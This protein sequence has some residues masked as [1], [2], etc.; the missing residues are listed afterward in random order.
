MSEV[1]AAPASFRHALQQYYDRRLLFIFILG[2]SSG[3]PWVLIGSAMSGWLKDANLSRAA[4]G[5]FG[6]VTAVYA[7][8]FL[9][10]PLVDRV[11]MPWLYQKVGQR[12]SWVLT[13]QSMVALLTFAIAFTNPALSLL[14]TSLLALLIGLFAAT[15]DVAIDGYRIDII[16]NEP[17]KLPAAAAM[18]VAG[19]WTGYSLPGYFAFH[20]ADVIGWPTVYLGLAVMLALLATV[21]LLIKEPVTNRDLLQQKSAE[22]YQHSTQHPVTLWLLVTV[23]EPFAEFFRRNGL[24]LSVSLIVFIL[25]FKLGEAFLGRMSIQFYRE[26]GFSNEQIAE[27]SKLIGWGATLAFTLLGSLLNVRFGV[28]KGLMLG[29][30]TMAGS[31]LMFAWIA[32]VGPDE[33]LLLWTILLDNFTTAFSIVAFVAFLTSFTGVAFSASQY[34]LLASIGNFARTSMASFGGALVDMLDGNWT[35]FFLMT[36]LMVIPALLLLL[37]IARMLK[38]RQQ[39]QVEATT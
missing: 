35:L 7:L 17:S 36:S 4:I 39:Q 21:T 27:Y 20:Y 1:A 26:V 24:W 5:Y 14:W 15:M 11:R 10:A 29:G 33:N 34:A 12:R 30:I 16:G 18:S 38:H 2:C 23:V 8:N 22:R 3:F 32:Q 9:W 13:M 28:I 19:W 37:L 6:S 31:N 25:T